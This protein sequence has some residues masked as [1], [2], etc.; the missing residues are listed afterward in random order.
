MVA[1]QPSANWA[2]ASIVRVYNYNQ[3]AGDNFQ[4]FYNEQAP[5]AVV[6]QTSP[7]ALSGRSS[8]QIG[9]PWFGYTNRHSWTLQGI[10]VAGG[11]APT[12]A[13]ASRP[14]IQGL[15]GPIQNRAAITPRVVLLTPWE[16]ALV[17]GEP[18][19]LRFTVNG[20]LPAGTQVY[21]QLD[22]AAPF[23]RPKDDILYVTPGAHRITAYIG[24]ASGKLVSGTIFASANFWY[25]P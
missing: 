22:G 1:G 14:E 19:R 25:A 24:D 7:A 20:L 10:A 16:G 15:V 23:S 21:F 8:E 4:V 2:Y 6:P 13:A 9:S 5:T 12:G 18:L 17:Q 11:V 3:V